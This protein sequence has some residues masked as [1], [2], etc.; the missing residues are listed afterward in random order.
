[1]EKMFGRVGRIASE[2]ITLQLINAKYIPILLYGLKACPLL[3]SDLSFLEFVVN[4][5]FMKCFEH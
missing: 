4:R 3:K 2:D 5:L 1:M